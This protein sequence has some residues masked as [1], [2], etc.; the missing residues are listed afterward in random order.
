MTVA[1]RI[2]LQ[3]RLPHD[4]NDVHDWHVLPAGH[5]SRAGMEHVMHNCLTEPQRLCVRARVSV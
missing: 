5:P 4:D 1:S 2:V 3:V